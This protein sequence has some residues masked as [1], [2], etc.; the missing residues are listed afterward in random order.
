[1]SCDNFEIEL[2]KKIIRICQSEHLPYEEKNI[3]FALYG[4]IND[5]DT[6]LKYG[7]QS[8]LINKHGNKSSVLNYTCFMEYRNNGNRIDDK[9]SKY[10][11]TEFNYTNSCDNVSLNDILDSVEKLKKNDE[12]K[13]FPYATDL[14]Y[15][16]SKKELRFIELKYGWGNYKWKHICCHEKE[17][18]FIKQ[19]N[20]LGD[21]YT[22]S[23]EEGLMFVDFMRM[24][25]IYD[26]SKTIKPNM[27]FVKFS[28]KTDISCSNI[29]LYCQRIGELLSNYMINE[30]KFCLTKGKY[31]DLIDYTENVKPHE[32]HYFYT[33]GADKFCK[34]KFD[35]QNKSFKVLDSKYNL[36][37]YMLK[38]I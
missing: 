17:C 4:D 13:Y 10:Y 2:C 6:N 21:S 34:D 30:I 9:G 11:K 8:N 24:I 23:E 20:L 22:I 3:K 1:M 26:N 27:Y 38:I 16:L 36:I 25:K 33:D 18:K 29:D 37:A 19:I 5:I 28:R 31:D 12:S 7:I 35:K 15:S 32:I 14:C